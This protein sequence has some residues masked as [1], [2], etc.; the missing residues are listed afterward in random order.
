MHMLLKNWQYALININ[1]NEVVTKMY[2][3]QLKYV[4]MSQTNFGYPRI[5]TS[6]IKNDSTAFH[7][8]LYR[9]K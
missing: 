6:T 7:Y 9:M 2:C 4:P 5:L 3:Y 8:K 1:D